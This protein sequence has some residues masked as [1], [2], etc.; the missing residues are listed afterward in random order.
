MD[1]LGGGFCS[2]VSKNERV[3]IRLVIMF[4]IEPSSVVNTRYMCNHKL[5]GMGI[6]TH[7]HVPCM[8]IYCSNRRF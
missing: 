1:D 3:L 7:T 4:E 2:S 8:P 5:S 6:D